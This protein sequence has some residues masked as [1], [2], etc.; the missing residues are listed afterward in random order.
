MK[1][2]KK[3]LQLIPIIGF[4]PS[5]VFAAEKGRISRYINESIV[6]NIRWSHVSQI[7]CYISVVIIAISCVGYILASAHKKQEIKKVVGASLII[8]VLVLETSVVSNMIRSSKYELSK[9]QEELH[10]MQNETNKDIN[11]LT[12]DDEKID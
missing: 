3:C 9:L 6:E 12:L 4:A 11:Q 7:I 2:L 8:S 10:I 5:N 1:K